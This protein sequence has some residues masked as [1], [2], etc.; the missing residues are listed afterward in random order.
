[1]KIFSNYLKEMKIA[2]RGF[3]FYI[4]I[5]FAVIVVLLLLFAVKETSNK[6]EEEFLFY[7]GGEYSFKSFYDPLFDSG[8]LVQVEDT[9]FK[10]KGQNIELINESTNTIENI[11]TDKQTITTKTIEHYDI[12]TGNLNKIIYETN[13]KDDLITLAHSENKIGAVVKLSLS[14]EGE[15]SENYEYYLRGY[16]SEKAL[17]VLSVYHINSYTDLEKTMTSQNVINLNETEILN[18]RENMLPVFLAFG[19]SVVGMFIVIAYVFLDKTEGTIKAMAV[20]P[21]GITSYL[22]SK[23]LVILTTCILSA[24]IVV[25]PIMKTKPDYVQLLIFIVTS[26]FMLSAFGLFL[27]SFYDNITQAFGVVYTSMLVLII[28]VFS[29]FM[30]S[31]N[32]GFLKILPTYSMLQG[33]KDILLGGNL[34]YIL[35]FSTI[36][37]IIGIIFLYLA[38]MKFKKTVA[39]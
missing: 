16:E 22:L 11:V 2:S 36:Y 9:E 6:V 32:L 38:N 1:M 17:N 37:S 10:V 27:S 14:K 30:P 29:Y 8:E 13:N 12:K 4:E 28:P 7:E 5:F 19:C 35:L 20:T 24:I 3:Y 15:Y 39:I 25:I 23:V 18:N 21:V 33:Y 26:S 34:S 31:L